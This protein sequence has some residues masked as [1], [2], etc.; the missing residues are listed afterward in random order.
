MPDVAKR[1]TE[2]DLNVSG[3]HGR[4]GSDA[5]AAPAPDETS[6]SP[7]DGFTS[8]DLDA[9]LLTT[10][11]GLGYE[12]PTPIQR[13]AIPP[14]LAGRDLLAE[15]PTGTG[16]TAAFALPTL[17]RIQVGKAG[18]G[19]TS[20]LVLVPTRELA[21]QVAEALHK[22]GRELGARILPVYGG[23]PI[24]Q[25]LRG[26]RRGV[27]VVV[28]TPGRA[29][30]HLKRGSLRFDAVEV[31]VLDEADEMLDMGFAEDLETILGATP[32]ERQTALFS[33]TISPTITRIA[34]RHLRDPARIKVHAEKGAGDGTAR[35]RQV[36]YVVRRSDKLAAL[37][38]ILD[39]EDPA[40]TLV[41]ARTRGEVDDLAE[42]LSARG[43][44]AGALH[45][46]L[47]QEAR[48]RMLGRFRDGSLDVLV[49]TD[50]AARGLDIEHVSHVVNYDVPSNPDAYVHR[51]GRTG[52]AGREGVAITLVEPREHRLLRNIE[53]ATHAKLEIAHLPTVADLR[54]RR[55]EIVRANLREALLG[56]GFDRYRGVV[57]PLTDEF[58]LVDIALAAVS[59]IEGAG[60]QDPD[61][62]ELFSPPLTAGPP[63]RG[64][65][66]VPGRPGR[67]P[68][69][70]PRPRARAGGAGP[71]R[72]GDRPGS[73]GP[74]VRLFV[75]GGRR[76]GLRPGDLVG[77]ITNE[78]GVPG[79]VIG[80]IQINDG[81]SLVDVQEGV[82][83]AVIAA[84]REATI[85]GRRLQVRRDQ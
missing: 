50:V 58:D 20:A 75:G 80:A 66:P 57:E 14:L 74:W 83:D 39:V 13:E 60:A 51:I 30:D 6:G 31:V 70:R 7:T 36:A 35:V 47:T 43:H 10:I 73:S 27:D 71:P 33:A 24:G 26:L 67:G 9:R 1:K 34:K 84:L 37:C 4:E 69:D 63:P 55:T 22:Y 5:L 11:A 17:Q 3:D 64:A 29:V 44:D 16:K 54:E 81:F 38:R 21:M 15:A 62:V 78:A 79:G 40:S 32:A 56:D 68:I 76:A 52:R 82:A 23:Q 77:A 45:G 19:S 48:D 2:T 42:A 41:F 85:R 18:E 46:G 28:A 49:A 61:E 25:Q 8:L 72:G 65:R 12:E 53:S 59:L